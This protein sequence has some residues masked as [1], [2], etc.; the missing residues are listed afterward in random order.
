MA[1]DNIT[2]NFNE[3]PARFQG[4]EAISLHGEWD[5]KWFLYTDGTLKVPVTD[6]SENLVSESMSVSM[7]SANMQQLNIDRTCTLT[8]SY[9]GGEQKRL[10]LMENMEKELA[11]ALNEKT[12]TERLNENK[13]TQNV[14]VEF[15]AAFKK[16][17]TDWKNYFKDE[18]KEQYEEEP[19]EVTAYSIKTDGMHK[20]LFSYQSTFT[21]DNFVK[22]AGNNYILDIGKL[23]GKYSKIE[24]KE[25]NRKIDVYMLSARTFTY[26]INFEI[27]EG[28]T[29]KGVEDLG[30]SLTNSTGS[31]TSTATVEGKLLKVT[32]IRKFANNFEQAAEWP[33]LLELLD[34]VYEFYGKKVLLEKKK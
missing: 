14:A 6:A 12:F 27:P 10:S 26:S 25:R 24:E 16:E 31:F 29:V 11:K 34:G 4:E 28:Y 23:I 33:K 9:H 30:K 5:R 15:A 8:G 13:R 22:K 20:P 7:M 21:M 2:T 19:R 32:V 1:F 17:K 3:I 18:I